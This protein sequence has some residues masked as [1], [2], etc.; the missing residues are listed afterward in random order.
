[1]RGRYDAVLA[2]I[3]AD[4]PRMDDLQRRARPPDL[5]SG[6]LSREALRAH[7]AWVERGKRTGDKGRLVLIGIRAT[8][9]RIG[10]AE[11]SG[12][13]LDDVDFTGVDLSY[14]SL[15]GAVLTRARLA[16]ANL[17]SVSMRDAEI[18]GAIFDGAAMA[19]AKFERAVVRGASFAGAD[20]DRSQWQS[21]HAT[22]TM[23]DGARLGNAALDGAA[24]ARCSF[25]RVDFSPT[26]PR[27]AATTHGARFDQCDLRGTRWDG[28]DLS[29]AIFVRCQMNGLAG[30]P[31]TVESVVVDDPDLSVGGD[32]SLIGTAADVLQ[33]WRK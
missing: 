17:T 11:L 16:R 19:L 9:E 32:R 30:H 18:R 27:P 24:F 1:M 26:T 29:G 33:M 6:E 8:G 31:S 22:D 15:V 25:H 13:R 5:S 4:L 14:A 7:E 3:V 23:F 2:E 21:A 12:A 28:R 10:A 20:L